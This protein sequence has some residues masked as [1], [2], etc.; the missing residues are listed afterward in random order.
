MNAKTLANE[1]N[2]NAKT[3]RA[4]LRKHH[5][6]ANDAKNT[7]WSIDAKIARACRKHFATRNARNA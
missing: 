4:Y 1:C 5:T 2:V 7:T 6:R 3:L